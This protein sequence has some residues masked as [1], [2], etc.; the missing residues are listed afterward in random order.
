M[1]K[2]DI[3]FTVGCRDIPMDGIDSL[4]ILFTNS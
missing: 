1:E 2:K 3:L 4:I